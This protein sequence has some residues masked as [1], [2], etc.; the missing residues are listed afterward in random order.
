MSRAVTRK[1]QSLFADLGPALARLREIRGLS[2]QVV[3]ERA[4]INRATLSRWE[5]GA[6]HPSSAAISR[7]LAVL[8]ADEHDLLE[9]AERLRRERRGE[10]EPG[11]APAART[12]SERVALLTAEFVEAVYAGQ[13]EAWLKSME[14]LLAQLKLMQRYLERLKSVPAKPEGKEAEKGEKEGEAGV[15]AGEDGPGEG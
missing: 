10:P 11:E 9:V 6:Y 14:S 13:G 7:L 3:A 15:A 4:G 2:Q 8:D 5:N 12:A 1:R